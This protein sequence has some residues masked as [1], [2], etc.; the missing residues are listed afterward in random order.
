MD[1]VKGYKVR[2]YPNVNQ[3][4][5]LLRTMGACRW[6]YNHFLEEKRDY[7]LENKKSLNYGMT[8]KQLTQLR[9]E[10]DWLNEVQFQPLQ[11]SLRQLDVAYNRF[12]RKQARF[13]KFKSRNRS[14]QTF[15]KVTGWRIEGN[16][17]FVANDMSMRFRGTFP[18]KREGTLT[19]SADA[20]GKWYAST[21]AIVTAKLPQLNGSV[22]LDMGLKS[23]VITSKGESYPKLPILSTRSEQKS[24][25]RKTKGSKSRQKAR[26]VLAKRHT[27]VT[28]I[29]K[30]HLHHI[31]KA[32]TSKNH[33]VIAVEDLAVK[34]MLRNHKLARSISNASWGELLRQL[35]YKQEWLGGRFVSIGRFFP[36]SKTCSTCHFILDTLP[37]SVRAWDCPKCNS[38][39]D[40]DV[41]AAKMILQ[42]AG[43][44]LGV[45]RLALATASA[46]GETSSVKLGYAQG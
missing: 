38:H 16:K 8:S 17:L 7:Y 31:S 24:L 29:R 23:L 5:S 43:E 37:L 19:I 13:P 2:I 46:G 20:S 27:K 26:S 32:I 45:E 39:H 9:K 35:K 11:Q 42:Q 18:D 6:I 3:R 36:S 21:Q 15:K 4:Q 30:N 44:L 33:A 22:G 10:V 1:I 28:N 14:K 12:F 25:S 40:R 41:N 34:N